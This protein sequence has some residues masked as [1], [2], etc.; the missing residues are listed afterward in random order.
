ML[1]LPAPT[2]LPLAGATRAALEDALSVVGLDVFAAAELRT[3]DP[4]EDDDLVL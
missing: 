2:D 1:E 4:F 3:N